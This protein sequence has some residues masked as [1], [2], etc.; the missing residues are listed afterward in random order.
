MNTEVQQALQD[1]IRITSKKNL[2]QKTQALASELLSYKEQELLALF[3]PYFKVKIEVL[4]TLVMNLTA[5]CPHIMLPYFWKNEGDP[6]LE[7][8]IFNKV[9]GTF[10]KA[11][12]TC[13][14]CLKELAKA[15]NKDKLS[16][17]Y[18]FFDTITAMEVRSVYKFPPYK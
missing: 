18:W 5:D 6:E 16:K 7:Q 4:Q 14:I 13:I 9:D 10:Q 15:P 17:Y 12:L 8:V 1:Y 2:P 3:K 11:I